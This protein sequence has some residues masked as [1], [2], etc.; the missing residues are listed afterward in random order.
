MGSSQDPRLV[1]LRRLQLALDA[2][3]KHL[4]EF[5]ARIFQS[6]QRTRARVASTQSA[7]PAENSVAV[8]IAA[9][10]AKFRQGR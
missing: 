7:V 5:E 6:M 1:E 3:I 10:M 4:D 2:A 8:H 9:G